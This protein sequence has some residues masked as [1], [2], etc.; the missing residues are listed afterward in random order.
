MKKARVY[1][2]DFVWYLYTH[3]TQ[4]EQS[5]DQSPRDSLTFVHLTHLWPYF[6]VG[7]SPNGVAKQQFVFG[8][9]GERSWS[10]WCRGH[11]YDSLRLKNREPLRITRQSASLKMLSCRHSSQDRAGARVV[12]G[13]ARRSRR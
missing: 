9:R 4:G 2:S 8:K 3:D 11:E 6:G 12:R 7:E 10:V 5:F 1:T 13:C